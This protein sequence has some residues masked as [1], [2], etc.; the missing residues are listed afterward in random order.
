MLHFV[1]VQA[2]SRHIPLTIAV[3]LEW[4]DVA[5]VNVSKVQV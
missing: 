1:D 5:Q 3:F 2:G 4:A